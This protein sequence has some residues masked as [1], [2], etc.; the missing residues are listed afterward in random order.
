MAITPI[1][2]HIRRTMHN[3]ST[4]SILDD[5]V[6]RAHSEIRIDMSLTLLQPLF[7]EFSFQGACATGGA[8]KIDI[9]TTNHPKFIGTLLKTINLTATESFTEVTV[10]VCNYMY[11]V[12]T[13]ADDE[14]TAS[15]VMAYI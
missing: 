9:Y 12:I 13:N 4:L 8:I 15:L 7:K 6:I 2:P 10:P 5:S 1:E 3:P 11:F 14:T